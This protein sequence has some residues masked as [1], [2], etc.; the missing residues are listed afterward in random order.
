MDYS[1]QHAPPTTESSLARCAEV[2]GWALLR[3][4]VLSQESV[5]RPR[6]GLALFSSAASWAIWS[7][8]ASLVPEFGLQVTGR[9]LALL[10]GA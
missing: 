5:S 4:A 7:L 8:G 1:S 6:D 2:L 9:D 3:L 10:E